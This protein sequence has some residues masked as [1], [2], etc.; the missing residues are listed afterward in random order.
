MDVVSKLKNLITDQTF[1][2]SF[3]AGI[4]FFSLTAALF[5]E[6]VLKLEPCI[7]CIY[8]RVPF[9]LAL[10]VS[11]VGLIVKR[12]FWPLVIS[13][14]GFLVNSG[15][16]F[17]HSGVERHWWKSMVEGCAVPDLG[18]DPQTMLE[19]ILSVPTGNCAEIP[20][21]DPILGLSM[22]NYNVFLCLGLFFVCALSYKLNKR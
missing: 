18:G 1:V 11:V 22:A 12:P 5:A 19:N 2:L 8:Q 15:I 9:V 13:G 6:A 3:I 14:A 20:W 10:A 17:Y 4:S 7:L 21:A 16:A